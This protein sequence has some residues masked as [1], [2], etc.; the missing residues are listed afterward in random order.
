[1]RECVARPRDGPL[2]RPDDVVTR[3]KEIDVA[4]QYSKTI[5]TQT[6]LSYISRT[7]L[8]AGAVAEAV[9][10]STLLTLTSS[11]GAPIPVSLIPF[12]VGV[13]LLPLSVLFSFVLRLATVTQRTPAITPFTTPEQ[14]EKPL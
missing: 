10:V 2:P 4:R 5:Y 11:S 9:L 8:Y 3:L 13:G 1:M 12:V 7:L 6:E 14:E